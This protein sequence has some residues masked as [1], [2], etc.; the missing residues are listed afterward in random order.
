MILF[1]IERYLNISCG[2]I[3]IKSFA[4]TKNH[5]FFGTL[6]QKKKIKKRLKVKAFLGKRSSTQ[7]ES[8]KQKFFGSKCWGFGAP[9]FYP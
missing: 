9:T 7:L 3:N 6:I 2:E 5:K 8:I 1:D 4:G